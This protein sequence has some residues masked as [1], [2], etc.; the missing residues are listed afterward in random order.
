MTDEQNWDETESEEDR[1]VR[2]EHWLKFSRS[3]WL[4]W[5]ERQ[6]FMG[7]WEIEQ[8]YDD[9]TG[10]MLLKGRPTWPEVHHYERVEVHKLPRTDRPDKYQPIYREYAF[11]NIMAVRPVEKPVQ[12]EKKG[13]V[14]MLRLD[15]DVEPTHLRLYGKIVD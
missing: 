14:T 4:I 1:D 5:K 13:Q 6:F 10:M 2:F 7:V 9:D 12:R 3:L 8:D 11:A 15:Q